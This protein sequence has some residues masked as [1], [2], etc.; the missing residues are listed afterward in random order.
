MEKVIFRLSDMRAMGYPLEYCRNLVNIPGQNFAWKQNP[1]K[2]NSPILIDYPE[3]LKF[4][5]K[6]IAR[7]R[8]KGKV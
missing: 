6:E 7:S 5:E 1:R 3:F 8:Q 2:E 4:R